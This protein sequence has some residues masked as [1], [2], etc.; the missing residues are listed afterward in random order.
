LAP[1][2]E[3]GSGPGRS[4]YAMRSTKNGKFVPL[5]HASVSMTKG[6]YKLHYYFGYEERDIPDL[7]KLF[8]VE[9]DPEEL[10]DLSTSHQ[11]IATALLNELKIKLAE[12]NEPYSS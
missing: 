4:V 1:F 7:V 3:S 6:Q 9:S 12:V 11:E 5:T 10:V 8:D 2:A